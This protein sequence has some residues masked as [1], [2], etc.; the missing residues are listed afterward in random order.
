MP[1]TRTP[2]FRKNLIALAACAALA[3]QGA[4][5]LDLV[6]EPPIPTSKSS[7]IAPNVIIS[8]DDSG[9]MDYCLNKESENN[10]DGKKD[11]DDITTPLADGTWPNTRRR[12]NVL[13]YALKKVFNDTELIT[14]KSMRIG[15]QV[16]W[17]NGKAPGVGTADFVYSRT[18][19]D[20]SKWVT[21]DYYTQ[22]GASSIDSTSIGT[23]SIKK[24]TSAHRANFISF[25]DTLKPGGGTPSH[26]MFSQAHKY[27]TRSL[28]KNGPWANV[29]G[30]TDEENTEY[31]GCRRNYHIMMT[32]GRWN[33]ISS[34]A[35]EN[36]KAITLGDGKTEYN[37]TSDQTRVHRD[38][39][40]K[41][42]ADWAFKSWATPLQSTGLK[43]ADKLSTTKDYKEAPEFETFGTVQLQKFWNP[44]Y[45]PATWP[46]MVTYTIGFSDAAVTWPGASTILKPTQT[47]PFGYDGSFPDFVTGAKTWPEMN[48]ENVR[49]LDL[50]HAAI[51]GRGRFYAVTKG[52]DL[53][54]AFKEIV[55]KIND[56]AA[57]LPD[58]I[59]GTGT[60]SGYNVSQ[61]NVGTFISAYSPKDAWMG[62]I[63]AAAI[64]KPIE[65]DC[66]TPTEPAKKC[67]K[68]PDPTKEWD[69]KTTAQ[70][71]DLLTNIEDRLIL[72][73]SD[74]WDS[75][76]PKGGVPFKWATDDSNLSTAQK[77]LLGKETSATS[78][79]KE[80]GL[81][82]LN[83]IRG[84]RSLEL[85]GSAAD[86][87]AKPFR[88]RKS[89][90]GDIVNSEIWYTGAPSNNYSLSG[91]GSFASA[92][93]DRT[94]MLY[95]GGNDG[96]LHGFSATDGNEKIAYVPRGVIANLKKLAD[97]DYN[98]QYFVDGSPMTGD[99]KLS[100]SWATLLVGSL[101]AGGKGYF[102]LDVTKPAD[103][104]TA[105]PA[106]LVKIDRTRGNGEMAPDCSIITDA[107]EKTACI[108]V[109]GEDKDIG[110]IVASPVRDASNQQRT[111]QITR[112]NNDRWAVVMGNGYNSAN[113]RPVLLVQYLDGAMELK[114]IQATTDATG[115]GNAKD[116]GLA[117]PALVDLDGNGR[118][119]VVYAGDNL[120]NLWKF[121]LTSASDGDWAVAFGTNT[122]LFTAQGPTTKG[123]ART[124][125]QPITAPPIVRAND[126]KM[127]D[128]VAVGGM[129]VAF[130]TGRNLTADD[131]NTDIKHNVQS[132]YSVLDNT[133]YCMKADKSSLELHPGGASCPSGVKVAAPTPAALGIG[134][135]A[136]KL[137]QQ[138]FK[139]V[140][141]NYAT[142]DPTTNLDGD[143]WKN[144][145]GWYLDLDLTTTGERLLKPMQF[146]DGSNILAV[147]TETPAGTKDSGSSGATNES[148]S[149]T[150]VATASGTQYRT[151]VNIMDGK[152]PTVQ[153]VD[154]HT[155]P[156]RIYDKDDKNVARAKVNTG[157]PMLITKGK[158]IID[159]TGGGG[160]ELNRMP[161]Q[162]LRPS[163]RQVK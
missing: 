73:W 23:N 20:G 69:G 152:I 151:L 108:K 33:S 142:V 63:Q 47:V 112:M 7:Y 105:T 96:M 113:Q 132:L 6:Q 122:P 117:A 158:R 44:K 157:T 147:Y 64:E 89:R 131:R 144:H 150:T 99:V 145:N 28:S 34:G 120:G 57:P 62:W 21:N 138:T 38:T 60:S 126:R 84:D 129:M 83:Y 42:L 67:P 124:Q 72:S 162:S 106:S 19:W 107:A 22:G 8:V 125:V 27:M 153:L 18:Y 52:E 141:G 101:G 39:H 95:A 26:L 53:V 35:N 111:T 156:K 45:N 135:S 70:R 1:R 4:L 114:R 97:P 11:A 91:Y 43:D 51:N 88:P 82:V 14:E 59:S 109:V 118:A 110:N 102:V 74:K 94:P 29:P 100:G 36:G 86:K 46:H 146:F 77:A 155:G 78:V 61:N 37:I 40:D 16:M 161:E 163:W 81:N 123:G 24:L 56:E 12:I 15:W 128:G 76:K 90:Q 160:E 116:N 41:T 54:T 149:P 68:F 93:K 121:D 66:P 65:V 13:K 139:V 17:N 98:H 25:V 136:A 50:W 119:D 10:C 3:P 115:I 55:G 140:D 104:A 9:S 159:M 31:L 154:I 32:D 87:D 137:A 143:A 58:N 2:Q 75:T 80:K 71:L 130:G 5:A 92:N 134:V 48:D 85:T 127:A 49:S 30:G 103:F 79:V 133:R 148:C